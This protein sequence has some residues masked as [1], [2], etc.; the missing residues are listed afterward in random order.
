MR[1]SNHEDPKVFKQ[2][3]F[4]LSRDDQIGGNNSEN[5]TP[6]PPPKDFKRNSQRKTLRNV[7]CMSTI[8]TEREK[9]LLESAIA[10][11]SAMDR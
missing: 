2:I 6:T 5:M 9:S 8:V 10:Q 11:S 4:N 7:R 1:T 3:R